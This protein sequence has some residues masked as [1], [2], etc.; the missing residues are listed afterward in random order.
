MIVRRWRRRFLGKRSFALP[1]GR[2][3]LA[4]SPSPKFGHNLQG[5]DAGQWLGVGL[6]AGTMALFVLHVEGRTERKY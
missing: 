6:L 3:H 2:P 1:Q 5:A 4:Q